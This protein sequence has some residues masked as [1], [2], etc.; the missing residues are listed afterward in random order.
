MAL[1]LKTSEVQASAGSNPAL[2]AFFLKRCSSGLNDLR[3]A[4][5]FSASRKV[6]RQHSLDIGIPEQIL[7]ALLEGRHSRVPVPGVIATGGSHRRGAEKRC[8]QKEPE[9]HVHLA[10]HQQ[11]LRRRPE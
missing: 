4:K 2:S 7:L 1:V 8:C 6:L 9:P 11:F 5:N 10:S 3:E